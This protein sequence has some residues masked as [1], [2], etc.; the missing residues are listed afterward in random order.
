MLKH[1]T[2]KYYSVGS[3][4]LALTIAETEFESL[5]S[6]YKLTASKPVFGVRSGSADEVATHLENLA[7]SILEFAKEWRNE[8]TNKDET[9]CEK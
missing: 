7:T 8:K 5:G 9:K 3:S 6:S 4:P 1:N 2:T